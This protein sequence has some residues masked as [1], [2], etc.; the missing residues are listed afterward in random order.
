[1]DNLKVNSILSLRQQLH[2]QPR[3]DLEWEPSGL[4]FQTAKTLSWKVRSLLL[5]SLFSES[6]FHSPMILAM[7]PSQLARVQPQ[8]SPQSLQLSQ[9]P[10]LQKTSQLHNPKF[11]TLLWRQ[12]LWFQTTSIKFLSYK[13]DMWMPPIRLLDQ[14]ETSIHSGSTLMEDSNHSRLLQ[15]HGMLMDQ[16]PATLLLLTH[17]QLITDQT[18]LQQPLFNSSMFQKRNLRFKE[19]M[20]ETRKPTV[21]IYF[22]TKEWIPSIFKKIAYSNQFCSIF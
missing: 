20:P 4:N 11:M 6:M 3:L 21:I 12:A 1:M 22:K 13:T 5:I 2:L 9:L 7:L 15:T 19:L 16:V 17:S 8:L 14:W 18:Q 10:L